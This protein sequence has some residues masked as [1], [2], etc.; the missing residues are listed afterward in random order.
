MK[1][2]AIAMFAGLAVILGAVWWSQPRP[3]VG[4]DYKVHLVCMGET[5]ENVTDKID[6]E[7]LEKVL[8][9]QTH[10][11][12]RKQFAPH[13]LTENTVEITGMDSRDHW[14]ILF[15]EDA[16]V[17]YDSAEKGGWP[18]QNSDELWAEVLALMPE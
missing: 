16:C 2:K 8:Q 3:L 7:A 14:H 9:G 12:F 4:E 1:K 5:L 11:R 10:G 6:V 18:I 15:C 17:I 13:Q